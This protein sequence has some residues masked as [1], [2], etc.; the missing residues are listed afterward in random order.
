MRC[1][2]CQYEHDNEGDLYGCPNCEG[3]SMSAK[4]EVKISTLKK[5][6]RLLFRR[7]HAFGVFSGRHNT[8]DRDYEL[9]LKRDLVE[10]LEDIKEL[11]DVSDEDLNEHLLSLEGK[12]LAS[13]YRDRRGAIALARATYKGLDMAHPPE[14]YK[15]IPS[16]V[17]QKDIF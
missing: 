16:W 17:N 15:H 14:H 12:D 8:C 3:E 9:F 1:P 13:L 10:G 11:L 6:A 2:F 4:I 5:F 7:G